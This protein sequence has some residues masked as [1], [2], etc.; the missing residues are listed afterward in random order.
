MAPD[1][2]RPECLVDKI[3][4]VGARLAIGMLITLRDQSAGPS[5]IKPQQVAARKGAWAF[6]T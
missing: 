3:R 5:P 4:R 6:A 1:S 2:I